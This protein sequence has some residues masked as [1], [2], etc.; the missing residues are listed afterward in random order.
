MTTVNAHRAFLGSNPFGD[1]KFMK[2]KVL[3]LNVWHGGRLWDEMIEF[4]V[5]EDADLLLL[6][7]VYNDTDLVLEPV[8][9]IC[10]FDI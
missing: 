5:K 1:T 10:L 6:Q 4:L 3:T 2:I 9:G 7:E 8:G